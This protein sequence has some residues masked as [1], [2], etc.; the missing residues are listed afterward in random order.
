VRIAFYDNPHDPPVDKSVTGGFGSI[1]EVGGLVGKIYTRLKHKSVKMPA[2]SMV[3]GISIFKSHGHEVHVCQK[4]EDLR[5]V[6]RL[7]YI[8][9]HASLPT[10]SKDLS[11]L[12]I[13]KKIHSRSKVIVFGTFP[14]ERPELYEDLSDSV[15]LDGEPENAFFAIASGEKFEDNIKL[16][17][18]ENLD[19]LPYPLWE[20]FNYQS[21]SYKPFLSGGSALPMTLTRGCPYNCSYC[22]YM[23]QQSAN[24]RYRTLT[25]TISEIRTNITNYN[26]R[27]IVF[28]DLVFTLNKNFI[29]ELCKDIKKHSL[30]F[31]FSIETRTDLL[32]G[33]I[34][35]TM[36]DIGLKHINLGIESFS[37]S[38]LKSI[39]RKPDRI[40]H[41][42]NVIKTAHELG[43]NI[44]AFYIIGLPHDTTEKIK[45]N[46]QYAIKLNTFGAQFCLLTPYPGTPLFEQLKGKLLT[47]DWNQFTEY[48][49][50]V[51]IDNITPS[52]LTQLRDYA[53]RTYYTQP[54]WIIKYAKEIISW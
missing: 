8:F 53:Y 11:N 46:I 44:S 16:G 23:P 4:T 28:R 42:E 26:V 31:Q 36:K 6:K 18:L 13:I 9:F 51:K 35:E 37:E 5:R 33:K 29:N 38:D 7:D 43:I 34:L 39:G 12:A 54:S 22:N 20:Y 30:D 47:K 49:P 21:F 41:Q 24:I 40:E 27:N 2:L 32:D 10:L 52:Q 15:I 3:Y 17:Q 45:K 50:V 48:R 1:T 14:K 19:S 25:N